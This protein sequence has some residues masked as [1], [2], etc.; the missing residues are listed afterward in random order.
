MYYLDLKENNRGKFLKVC[1]MDTEQSSVLKKEHYCSS[2]LS[3][4]IPN[5]KYRVTSQSQG[6][7]ET[8]KLFITFQECCSHKPGE[9][10]GVAFNE[11]FSR[12]LP[13]FGAY[14]TAI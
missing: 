4:S 12:W 11:I 7:S 14:Q 3:Q 10:E 9:G 13:L 8:E 1:E 6:Y 5:R 2:C